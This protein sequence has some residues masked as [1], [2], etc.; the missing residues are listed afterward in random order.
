MIFDQV[1]EYFKR[2]GFIV[3]NPLPEFGVIFYYINPNLNWCL[4]VSGAVIFFFYR[5]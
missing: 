5:A 2:N 1:F 4:F 3:C